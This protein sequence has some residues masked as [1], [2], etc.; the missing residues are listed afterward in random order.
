[1]R[2]LAGCF[3]CVLP[4]LAVNGCQQ[5]GAEASGSSGAGV[6]LAELQGRWSVASLRGAET[7]SASR[8]L[9]EFSAPPRLTGNGGCNRFFGMYHY[10]APQLTIESSLGSTKMACEPS[11]MVEEQTLFQLL[12]EAAQVSVSEQGELILKGEDGNELLRA[13]RQ[14]Q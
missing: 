1:M 3:L 10:D 4:L 13:V 8:A 12:P 6:N 9:L 5:L 2:R 7:E 11:V 14:S